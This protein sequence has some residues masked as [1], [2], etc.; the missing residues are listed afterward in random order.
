MIWKLYEPLFC[1]I[2]WA[3]KQTLSSTRVLL[4]MQ[5]FPD[6]WLSNKNRNKKPPAIWQ[7]HI[8]FRDQRLPCQYLQRWTYFENNFTMKSCYWT[9]WYLFIYFFKKFNK[10]LKKWADPLRR[11]S[12]LCSYSTPTLQH[13]ISQVLCIIKRR[14]I[15]PG[16]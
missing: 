15:L 8:Y 5:V 3:F 10:K 16:T 6:Y 2:N 13:T 4:Y 1:R 7:Q 14:R 12:F 11:E 9:H